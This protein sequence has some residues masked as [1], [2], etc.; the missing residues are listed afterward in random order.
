MPTPMCS[1]QMG[2]DLCIQSQY[3]LQWSLAACTGVENKE[4]LAT[5]VAQVAAKSA[6]VIVGN[7]NAWM[8]I[9]AQTDY[10]NILKS[11]FTQER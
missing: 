9:S 10:G 6:V 3:Q 1:L 8:Q 11:C 2:T 7:E 5:T 4:S